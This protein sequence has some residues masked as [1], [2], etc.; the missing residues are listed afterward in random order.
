MDANTPNS[1]LP[2]RKAP[3]PRR[4]YGRLGAFRDVLPRWGFL[5]WIIDGLSCLF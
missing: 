2:L 3:L 4:G 1:L 5:F